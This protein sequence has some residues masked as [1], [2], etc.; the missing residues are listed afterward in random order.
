MRDRCKVKNIKKRR[1]KWLPAV[2][3][4]ERRKGEDKEKTIV[5][6]PEKRK[7]RII[8]SPLVSKK[9]KETPRSSERIR[10]KCKP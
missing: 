2:E 3:V 4:E 6:A 9:Q 8:T 1:K 10:K 7:H 5:N